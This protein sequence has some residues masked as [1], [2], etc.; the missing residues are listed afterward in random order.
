MPR[1]NKSHRSAR[2]KINERLLKILWYAKQYLLCFLPVQAI[3][4]GEHERV[5]RAIKELDA[6]L[7]E[8][9]PHGQSGLPLDVRVGRCSAVARCLLRAL[10]LVKVELLHVRKGLVVN[11]TPFADRFDILKPDFDD[12]L[13]E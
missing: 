2:W 9:E 13:N 7:F 5:V 8:E 3:F 10:V 12:Q 4:D 6:E 1:G 11:E